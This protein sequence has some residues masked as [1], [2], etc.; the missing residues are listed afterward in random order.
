MLLINPN[1]TAPLKNGNF[2]QQISNEINNIRDK[3]IVT[4]LL[5]LSNYYNKILIIYGHSHYFTQKSIIEKYFGKPVYF[6]FI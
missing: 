5:K 2:I 3:H 4:I 1:F 6:N